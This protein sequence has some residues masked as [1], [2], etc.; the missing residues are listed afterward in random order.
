[1]G[2]SLRQQGILR[3]FIADISPCGRNIGN[4]KM[5]FTALPKAKTAFRM[6]PRKSCHI[7]LPYLCQI[8][9]WPPCSCDRLVLYCARRAANDIYRRCLLDAAIR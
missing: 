1:V 9:A 2:F 7:N 8:K 3:F 4:K 6:R 5:I